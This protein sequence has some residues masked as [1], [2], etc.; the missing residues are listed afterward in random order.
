MM[1]DF[2]GYVLSKIEGKSGTPEKPLSDLG[3]LSYRS[4]WSHAIVETIVKHNESKTGNQ[5]PSLSVNDIVERTAIKKDD[6]SSTLNQLNLVQ[7][8][9]GQYIITLNDETLKVM[10]NS[11]VINRKKF[12]YKNNM[13][14]IR[15]QFY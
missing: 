13:I 12:N 5:R 15:E 1:S 3:L 14:V 9:Q 4:Y 8:F 10:L 7:Y 11:I 2:K 6:V